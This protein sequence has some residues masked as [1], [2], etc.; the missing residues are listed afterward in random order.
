V[1]I[2]GEVFDGERAPAN[3][4]APVVFVVL[5]VA[6]SEALETML[7]VVEAVLLLAAIEAGSLS[8]LGAAS[9][10][11]EPAAAAEVGESPGFSSFNSS[12][13]ALSQAR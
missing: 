12:I 2:V 7:G 6:A 8:G 9:T 10:D 3:V 13:V 5:V 4:V 1:G 11:D